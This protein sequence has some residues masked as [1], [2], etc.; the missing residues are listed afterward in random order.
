MLIVV[1]YS[2]PS[3]SPLSTVTPYKSSLPTNFY[4]F[5]R[6]PPPFLYRYSIKILR[7]LIYGR[8]QI[9]PQLFFVLFRYNW[10]MIKKNKKTRTSIAIFIIKYSALRVSFSFRTTFFYFYFF[11]HHFF[12]FVKLSWLRKKISF[13]KLASMRKIILQLSRPNHGHV[14]KKLNETE[15]GKK[16]FNINLFLMFNFVNRVCF[17]E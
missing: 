5:P 8:L 10:K 9:F 16:V 2:L 1:N 17:G 4:F 3:P 15:K 14:R 7:K 6:K 12:I 13:S 11:I